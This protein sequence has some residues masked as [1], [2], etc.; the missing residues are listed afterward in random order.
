MTEKV[1][2]PPSPPDPAD[3]DRGA[4]PAPDVPPPLSL[5]LLT[6]AEK[7]DRH[8]KYA[9]PR[10]GRGGGGRNGLF[11]YTSPRRQRCTAAEVSLPPSPYSSLSPLSA[12]ASPLGA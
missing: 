6:G 4:A 2:L 9:A 3:A 7:K 8:Q 11:I 10:A 1:G 5:R 12:V